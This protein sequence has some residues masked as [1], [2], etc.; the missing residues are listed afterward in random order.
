MKMML[1][2]ST[3]RDWTIEFIYADY[4]LQS[5]CSVGAVRIIWNVRERTVCTSI[6]VG[7]VGNDNGGAQG[8]LDGGRP[9]TE[10]V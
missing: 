9:N 8:Q 5:P 1:L 3:H 10:Y 4:S 2:S 7:T 6:D